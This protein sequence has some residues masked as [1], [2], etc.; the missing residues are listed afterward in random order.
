MSESIKSE[1]ISRRRAFSLFKIFFEN[2]PVEEF[3]PTNV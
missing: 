2:V 1:L 3:F